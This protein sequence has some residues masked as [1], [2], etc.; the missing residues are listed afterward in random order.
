MLFGV[1][2]FSD[3]LQTVQTHII[4]QVKRYRAIKIRKTWR[5]NVVWCDKVWRNNVSPGVYQIS[6]CAHCSLH[7][8][9][10]REHC[11]VT[12]LISISIPFFNLKKIIIAH[13]SYPY[14]VAHY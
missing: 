8:I 2:Q 9:S 14:R 10:D 4:N 6:H 7:I 13:V 12:D 5:D 1:G 3:F 11:A